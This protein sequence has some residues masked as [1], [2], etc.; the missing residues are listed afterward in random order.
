MSWLGHWQDPRLQEWRASAGRPCPSL[1]PAFTAPGLQGESR[2]LRPLTARPV[3]S[4]PAWA[5]NARTDVWA[6]AGGPSASSP[7]SSAPPAL[8]LASFLPS[9]S[10]CPPNPHKGHVMEK[11]VMGRRQE[12]PGWGPGQGRQIKA[13]GLSKGWPGTRDRGQTR[14]PKGQQERLLPNLVSASLSHVSQAPFIH[15]LILVLSAGARRLQQAWPGSGVT[16]P[17][18]GE[19]AILPSQVF[20]GRTEAIRVARQ[21]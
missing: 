12:V 7:P 4:R 10:L 17:R 6:A 5:R 13:G 8:A 15:S 21:G 16:G 9:R 3:C 19:D 1:C 18:G 14:A 20:P 2:L 11:L